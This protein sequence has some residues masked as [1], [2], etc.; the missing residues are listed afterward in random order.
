MC[1]ALLTTRHLH[2]ACLRS[3]DR[4]VGLTAILLLQELVSALRSEL[5]IQS[6]IALLRLIALRLILN[7]LLLLDGNVIGSTRS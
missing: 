4:S 7:S 2:L 3:L 6:A 1:R 5:W